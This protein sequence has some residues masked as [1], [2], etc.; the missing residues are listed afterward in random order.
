[1]LSLVWKL[2]LE[3]KSALKCCPAYIS[4]SISKGEDYC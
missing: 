3:L 4:Y 1:M 2:R